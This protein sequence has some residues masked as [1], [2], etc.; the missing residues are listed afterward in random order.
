MAT[1]TNKILA[2]FDMVL[3]AVAL[4]AAGVERIKAARERVAEEGDIS[5]EELEAL[6]GELGQLADDLAK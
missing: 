5:V 2:I 6:G 4:G 3:R 1:D